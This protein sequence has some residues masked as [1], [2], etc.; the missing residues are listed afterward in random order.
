MIWK[1][2][3]AKSRFSEVVRRALTRGPQ[4]IERRNDAVILL[5]EED[6]AL[7]TGQKPSFRSFLLGG[8][9]LEDL[10]LDRN[11]DE[12]RDVEL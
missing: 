2:A 6:Y 12:M 7:L 9:S 4:R 5:S 3:E 10:D 11:E 8:P 1:L